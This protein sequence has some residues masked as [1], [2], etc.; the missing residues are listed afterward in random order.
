MPFKDLNLDETLQRALISE[1]YTK[2][3][4]IQQQSIPILLDHKDLL[5]IAQTGTGK[6]AAFALPIIQTL[7]LKPADPSRARQIK[8]LILCPTRELAAQIGQNF[9][10]Y[11]RY[12]PVRTGVV[13]GGVPQGAQETML[14]SGVDVLIATPGRLL[15]LMGQGYIY[16]GNLEWFVLDEAD[17]MLDMG[18]IPDIK[19][20]IRQLPERRQS[21]FLSATIPP[22]AM[23]LAHAILHKPEKVDV[24]EEISSADT[25][26]QSLYL[27]DKKDKPA[28]LINLLRSKPH[29]SALVFTRTKTSA[30]RVVYSLIHAGIRSESIHGNKAQSA[31][32]L[33]L[34]NFKSNL[35]R[36]LVATDIAARGIDVNNLDMVI[37]YELPNVSEM[38]I[39]RIGRT[40]RAGAGG[41]A[42]SFCDPDEKNYLRDIHKLLQKNIPLANDHPFMK[43]ERKALRMVKV[44]KP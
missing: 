31:R 28:L 30:D 24:T 23:K 20:I 37:N 38:Y 21:V 16:F 18:F 29:A 9:N 27:V 12:T 39:H 34:R 3:T 44:I 6:T 41:A 33:A 5:A 8:A 26:N 14:R 15:D 43:Q 35:T 4:P 17:L 40:G 11:A 42:L 19:R 1:G 2:P 36:V 10:S 13:F 22:E 32:I 25:I 7:L